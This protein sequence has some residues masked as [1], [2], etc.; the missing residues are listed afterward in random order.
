M[1]ARL[2][3]EQAAP[4]DASDLYRQIVLEHA[5]EPRNFGRLESATHRANGI[6]ALCGDKLALYVEISPEGRIDAI[7]F[8][9]TGCAISL[10][11]ASL[12]TEAVQGRLVSEA[13][14][15]SARFSAAL[16]TGAG[17]GDSDLAALTAVRRYPSR[18]R[19]ATL[20]WHALER[21][22]ADT[23]DA[24]PPTVTTE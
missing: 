5:K 15:I 17:L 11:S 7:R 2:P 18:V 10:A 4:A 23:S 6:N 24:G 12:M 21:A 16:E 3:D 13:L 14:S 22:V 9:G 1:S 20:A 19:C 8:D